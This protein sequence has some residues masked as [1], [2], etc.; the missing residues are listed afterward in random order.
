[1]REPDGSRGIL[2]ADRTILTGKGNAILSDWI[3]SLFSFSPAD[4]SGWKAFMMQEVFY[5]SIASIPDRFY[6]YDNLCFSLSLR[7]L[8]SSLAEEQ[9]IRLSFEIY[10]MKFRIPFQWEEIIF[11]F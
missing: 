5:L 11:Y 9:D 2:P 3:C 1:M 7:L 8:V 6:H 10:F 4:E